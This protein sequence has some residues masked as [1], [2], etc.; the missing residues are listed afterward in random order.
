M[1][2]L[3]SLLPD[4]AVGM[5]W[6]LRREGWPLALVFMAQHVAAWAVTVTVLSRLVDRR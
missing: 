2:L 3:V 4:I 6:L 1:A 5:G